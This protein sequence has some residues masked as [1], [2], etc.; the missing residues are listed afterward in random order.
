MPA[1]DRDRHVLVVDPAVVVAHD[2]VPG[3]DHG[4]GDLA[5]AGKRG[6]DG[7]DPDLD[8]ALLEQAQEPP[9]PA[10]AAIF[11]NGFDQH[12]ARALDR[13]ISDVGQ[14]GLGAAVAV[15]HV[16]FSAALVVERYLE[17]EPR[18]PRPF[19]IGQPLAV[20]DHVAWIRRRF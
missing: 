13:R 14:I 9:H 1:L 5:V 4:G 16:R 7:Q 2:L 19:R 17:R 10:P 18:L 15:Q 3:L 8:L 6:R 20:S 12:A 11:K